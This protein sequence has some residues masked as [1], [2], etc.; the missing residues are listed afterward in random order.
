MLQLRELP[1]PHLSKQLLSPVRGSRSR[2]V[3]CKTDPHQGLPH[4]VDTPSWLLNVYYYYYPCT[5]K[6]VRARVS[7]CT[8]FSSLKSGLSFLMKWPTR[9]IAAFCLCVLQVVHRDLA[10]RNM[11]IGLNK[12]GARLKRFSV[13]VGDFGLARQLDENG[14]CHTSPE[15][16][17]NRHDHG[18][19]R[20]A[21]SRCSWPSPTAFAYAGNANQG[22]FPYIARRH[23]STQC[24]IRTVLLRRC[25]G[26]HCLSAAWHV[27][28]VHGRLHVNNGFA[29]SEVTCAIS[30]LR[31]INLWLPYLRRGGKFSGEVELFC[32]K[33]IV[34][35]KV[36]RKGFPL[37]KKLSL[38]CRT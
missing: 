11:L 13:K 25:K 27:R 16:G 6:C 29:A 21:L 3:F 22:W 15:V 34:F 19:L 7:D 10:A 31:C 4:W 5:S 20:L 9:T 14:V 33:G 24:L 23:R 35:L 17:T 36:L 26:L 37:T 1:A 30:Q 2:V 32:Q 18:D 12:D 8:H 28:S 38:Q